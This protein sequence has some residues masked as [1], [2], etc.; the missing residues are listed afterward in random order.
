MSVLISASAL[1][2]SAAYPYLAFTAADGTE[3]VMKTD[4]LEISY[5]SGS[6]RA[7]NAA[8]AVLT[9]DASQLASMQFV[10]DHPLSASVIAADA[11][12]LTFFTADGQT[13]GTF[14]NMEDACSRLPKGIY[15]VKSA[16]GQTSKINLLK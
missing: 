8:N 14:R 15:V 13:A 7:V 6:L 11:S 9:L 16:N 1:S 2:A 5:D 10:S 4:G 12:E 3:Y